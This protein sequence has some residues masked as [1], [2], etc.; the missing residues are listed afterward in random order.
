MS[1]RP[2]LKYETCA[3][4]LCGTIEKYFC[5][6][7]RHYVSTCG[8]RF[9]DYFNPCE[10]PDDKGWAAAGV[11]PIIRKQLGITP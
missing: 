6:R 10:C 1:S 11:R 5:V 9:N 7:C 8:C 3:T 4:P 2:N